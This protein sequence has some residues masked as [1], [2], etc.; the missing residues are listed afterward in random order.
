MRPSVN[1]GRSNK[2]PRS[3][4]AL[5]VEKPSLLTGAASLAEA[6]ET[7]ARAEADAAAARRATSEAV[8]ALESSKSA[9]EHAGR[10]A[11]LVAAVAD[12][13]EAIAR[14][15]EAQAA[16][17][18]ATTPEVVAYALAAV[19]RSAHSLVDFVD[20][21]FAVVASAERF[22]RDAPWAAA[23][24]NVLATLPA[25]E[26]EAKLQAA[27]RLSGCGFYIEC[28]SISCYCALA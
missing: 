26:L 21:A 18:A 24:L 9:E 15:Q 2:K 6:A 13:Q 7:L 8:A 14:R 5:A 19:G 25:D 27:A 16:F 1:L 23:V 11:A 12:Q 28:L 22:V 10:Q 3:A 4:V 17:A 20:Q